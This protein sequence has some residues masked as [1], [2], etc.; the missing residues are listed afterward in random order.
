M[1][2]CKLVTSIL[3]FVLFFLILFQSC[4]AGLSNALESSNE[5]SG[6]AGV[7]VACLMLAGAIVQLVTRNAP[8]KGAS[9][10]GFVLFL[11]AALIGFALAGSFL[12]LRIWA[13]WCLLLGVINLICL[14][15]RPK[16]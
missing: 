14:L 11:L 12:D 10:A 5:V 7:L 8:S 15:R 3:C 16:A 2:T 13:A 4:A 9:T 1:K 6:F